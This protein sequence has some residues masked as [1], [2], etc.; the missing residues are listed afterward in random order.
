MNRA[1]LNH[2]ALNQVY[3]LG[4]QLNMQVGPL[5]RLKPSETVV[6]MVESLERGQGVPFHK[7]KLG[8]VYS[9]MR[10]FKLELERAGFSVNYQSCAKWIDG[11]RAHLEQYPGA[12]LTLM[13]PADHGVDAMLRGMIETY[14][15]TLEVVPNELWLSSDADFDVFAKGKK[16]L[17]MEF[18]YRQM[19]KKT[20]W[21][22]D[23]PDSDE[24]VGGSWNYDADNREVP[25]AG[26][27]FPAKLQFEHDSLT[28]E[29]LAWVRKNFPDNF[30]SLQQFNWPVTR[31][32]AL[33][34][35]EHFLE[36][37]LA[38]FGPFEDAMVEGENQ[39]YHSMI[40]PALNIGLLTATEVCEAAIQFA[41]T[42]KNKI[43][44][45]SI[46]GF[47]RQILGWR[48]FMRHVYR[49]KMPAFRNENRLEHT[50]KLPD[51]Y[52]SGRTTMR[53]LSQSVTQVLETGHSHHI[54]RLM[55]LGN[56]ALI[57]GVRP[58]EINDWF[59]I[60]Y[61]DAFDWVVSP[62]VLGMSQYADLDSFTS[63]PY[64]SGG[65]YISRMSNHCQGCK[66][67]HKKTVGDDACPFSSLYWDFLDR[68]AAIFAKNQRMSMIL[69][70]WKKRDPEEKRAILERARE[71]KRLLENDQL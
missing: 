21:L 56:F 4:D 17:R 28:L 70:S 43:P 40:S 7:Q 27:R 57:A 67:N 29:T 49:T 26:H 42:P 24:P 38:N 59:L 34:A 20:G 50:A 45:S 30:G 16:S 60:A 71:I 11:I 58:Q 5:S 6:L 8:L 12:R 23:D 65:A 19:R 39:L 32:Q 69:A 61:V 22:M 66:F 9:A 25:P 63:K 55:V 33:M 3:V 47:I 64:A 46:E 37:R 14:A 52:W 68:H 44:L 54:Q 48:E 35:L 18:F 41:A 15:G 2:A 62:N 13:Q 31:K 36:H 10:H 53:C 1:A 51:L